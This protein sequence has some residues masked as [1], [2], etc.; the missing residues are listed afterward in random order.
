MEVPISEMLKDKYGV[1]INN[2][3]LHQL[4]AQQV[5]QEVL[6][7]IP[8]SDREQMGN[9]EQYNNLPN[10][11]SKTKNSL[12]GIFS[13][14]KIDQQIQGVK[15]FFVDHSL[16]PKI[17]KDNAK[18]LINWNTENPTIE[19]LNNTF[20]NVKN[21]FTN[22]EEKINKVEHTTENSIS[23]RFENLQNLMN[24]AHQ[25]INESNQINHLRDFNQSNR[26]NEIDQRLD[27][28]NENKD[29]YNIN[30]FKQNIEY[31]DKPQ[32]FDIYNVMKDTQTMIDYSNPYERNHNT[33]NLQ[34]EQFSLSVI[35]NIENNVPMNELNES[36]I[37]HLKDNTNVKLPE[38]EQYSSFSEEIRK[39]ENNLQPHE[40]DTI[41]QA[42]ENENINNEK[43]N[44]A[45]KIQENP[46][47]QQI[48][49]NEKNNENEKIN[50]EIVDVNDN[51]VFININEEVYSVSVSEDDYNK[52]EKN[53]NNYTFTFDEKEEK[54]T[55]QT[56]ENKSPH[57]QIEEQNDISNETYDTPSKA[58]ENS[59]LSSLDAQ[60]PPFI[61]ENEA[62]ER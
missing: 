36:R 14:E 48:N 9:N 39:M 61:E 51:Q 24:T 49:G 46:V 32:I 3:D 62:I 33:N 18:D 17:I 40:I 4:I 47:F 30:D 22:E 29:V 45:Y 50:C 44:E 5:E 35:Q 20:S 56:I 15:Q 25:T 28:S 42:H 8:K 1:D 43:V 2:K 10:D 26:L 27:M 53:P 19:K 11:I 60:L 52:I 59:D 55:Y 57:K 12:K 7:R 41:N 21:M 13:K 16:T 37:N 31:S 38:T 34:I 58:P 23:D 6:K 54:L